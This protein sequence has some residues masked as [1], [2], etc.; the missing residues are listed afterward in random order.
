MEKIKLKKCPFCGGE[1]I[2]ALGH[3]YRKEHGFEGEYVV[4]IYCGIQTMLCDSPEK[5]AMLWNR[6]GGKISV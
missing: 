1:A 2:F 3:D 4:C 6:R 5:A